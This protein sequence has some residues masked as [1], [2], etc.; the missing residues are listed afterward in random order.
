MPR[1]HQHAAVAR[2]QRKDV[3]GRGDIGRALGGVDGHGD[4]ARA[5]SWA[6][7]PVVTPSRASIEVVKAV[8]WREAFLF[9][10]SDSPSASMRDPGSVRQISPRP[11]VAMKLMAEGV[12][13]WAGMTRSPAHDPR[14]PQG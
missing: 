1:A 12:R 6:E 11:C 9:D 5:R 7:M 13:L 4:G 8:S 2:A 10:I 3:A 14:G